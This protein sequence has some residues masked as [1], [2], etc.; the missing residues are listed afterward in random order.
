MYKQYYLSPASKAEDSYH[1]HRYSNMN[2]TFEMPSTVVY[3]HDGQILSEG[4]RVTPSMFEPVAA[5]PL[6]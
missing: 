4:R 3:I 6:H 5:H 2:L 1:S